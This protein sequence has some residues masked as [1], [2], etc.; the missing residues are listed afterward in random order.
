MILHNSCS[1]K[2]LYQN[3]YRL[4]SKMVLIGC[5]Y[6]PGPSL[7][8]YY[9]RY[10]HFYI[11]QTS[12]KC[13]HFALLNHCRTIFLSFIFLLLILLFQVSPLWLMISSSLMSHFLV[14]SLFALFFNRKASMT[15]LLEH[16]DAHSNVN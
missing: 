10:F 15:S 13:L 1:E 14:L 5:S 6:Q 11:L 3:T 12:L 2:I 7:F 4:F 9:F 8:C 16:S